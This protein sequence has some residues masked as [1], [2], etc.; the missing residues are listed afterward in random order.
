VAKGNRVALVSNGAGPMVNAID[1]F[2]LRGLELVKLTRES[3]ARMREKFSFFYIVE[4]PVDITGSA[5]GADYEFVIE[6]LI[7]DDTVDIIMP[8]F[9]FQN[10]PLDESIV[11]RL[12][13]LNAKKLKPI[14]CCSTG[15]SYSEKMGSA[16]EKAGIPV[17][18]RVSE[19]VAASSAL[20]QWARIIS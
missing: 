12:A 7:A 10:A 3:F 15:G 20:A 18:T 19:W 16:I 4:N 5:T 1:L 9:V 11:D 6:T 17:F 2:P 13:T 14:V 8:F